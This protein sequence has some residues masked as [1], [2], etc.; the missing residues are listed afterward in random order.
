[1]YAT[2]RQE[3]ILAVIRAD[4][5]AAVTALAADLAVTTETIRRD[6]DQLERLGRVR[7]VHGGAVDPERGSL[8]EP[9]LHARSLERVETKRAIADAAIARIPAGST[10]LIDA[11]SSTGAVATALAQRG[12]GAG[13]LDVITNALP[14]AMAL[15]AVPQIEVTFIGGRLRGVTSASVGTMAIAQLAGLRPDVAV[16]GT[17]GISAGFGLSTP[18]EDE[19]ATKSAMVRAAR[20]R[21][22]VADGS[23]LGV[24]S[25][26][27][28]A[29]LADLD[30]LVTDTPPGADL[31]AALGA[32]DVEVV[33]A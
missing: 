16:L 30:T 13:R 27:S 31:T 6:L 21:I 1:M 29:A 3:H 2:E 5:R 15:H 25:L 12:A 10:L 14:I 9:T 32:A 11:G 22:V 26:H 4:G 24:E 23:K 18:D 8:A 17:N 33:I 20:R 28:F 19:A 7:R